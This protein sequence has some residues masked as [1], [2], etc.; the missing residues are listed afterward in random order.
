MAT[1]VFRSGENGA[2]SMLPSKPGETVTIEE[3]QLYTRFPYEE[4]SICLEDVM[5]PMWNF[6]VLPSGP[7]STR[8]LDH[9]S[10]EELLLVALPRPT[11]R[12]R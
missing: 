10:D 6:L 4:G 8:V 9:G 2:T 7:R 12:P 5:D 3:S 1:L 11:L